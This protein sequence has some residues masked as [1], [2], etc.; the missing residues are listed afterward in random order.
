MIGL[1]I[2]LANG[3][4]ALDNV[5]YSLAFGLVFGLWLFGLPLAGFTFVVAG[6]WVILLRALAPAMGVDAARNPWG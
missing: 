4:F 5:L 2:P 1:T 3:N 6:V